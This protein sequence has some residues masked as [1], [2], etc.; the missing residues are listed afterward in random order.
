MTDFTQRSREMELMDDTSLSDELLDGALRDISMLNK[1]LGGNQITL[2]A[3]HKL[4]AQF[5]DKK[6]WSILDVGCGNGE[7]LRILADSF[8]QR[9]VEVSFYGA[10]LSKKS[11]DMAIAQS[12][13]YSTIAYTTQDILTLSP[14]EHQYDII[15]CTLTLHHIRE[16]DIVPFLAKFAELAVLGLIINDLQRSSLS[17]QL[18][19]LIS[20]IFIK[21]PIAKNDGLVSIAS[22]F[23]RADFERYAQE[24]GLKN[25]KITWKWAFRYLWYIS[26]V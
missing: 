18:F 10:D 22:A 11:I 15:I 12:Q 4:V 5:P 19:K 2:K 17:Y 3:V 13:E 23:K 16:E 20:R 26:L 21:S 24:L 25:H 9:D 8:V 7:M 1:R 14:Q 6:K